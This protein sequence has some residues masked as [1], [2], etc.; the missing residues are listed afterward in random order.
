VDAAIEGGIDAQRAAELD[1]GVGARDI[2]EARGV[3]RSNPDV[4]HGLGLDRKVGRV[5]SV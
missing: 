1:A 2:E 4:F 5:K 3:K